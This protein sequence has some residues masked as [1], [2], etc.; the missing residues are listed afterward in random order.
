MSNSFSAPNEL[1]LSIKVR[2]LKF[3]GFDHD[4]RGMSK[5][6]RLGTTFLPEHI[7]VL[8]GLMVEK[9]AKEI[10]DALKKEA[11]ERGIPEGMEFDE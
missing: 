5:V 4:E 10:E 8:V 6:A 2:G 9:S 11:N 1:V 3:H 7:A